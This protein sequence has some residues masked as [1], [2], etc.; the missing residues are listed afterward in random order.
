[1]DEYRSSDCI[2]Y[3]QPSI[4][5]DRG[6]L[7]KNNK[8]LLIKSLYLISEKSSK[9]NAYSLCWR[10]SHAG[11]LQHMVDPHNFQNIPKILIVNLA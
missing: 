1:M 8:R 6:N 11:I 3:I 9:I 7:K 4:Q 5:S 2:L 10:K